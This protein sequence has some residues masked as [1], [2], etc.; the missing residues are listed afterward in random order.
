MLSVTIDPSGIYAFINSVERDDLF[1]EIFEVGTG[2]AVHRRRL[3]RGLD[4]TCLS[5]D[6]KVT[7]TWGH[8]VLL[9]RTPKVLSQNI[10]KVLHQP[11]LYKSLHVDDSAD[12][13]RT[14]KAE[15]G[16]GHFSE[17]I[18]IQRTTKPRH[19]M[20]QE[21]I[22]EGYACAIPAQSHSSEVVDVIVD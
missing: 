13:R 4:S 22:Y 10:A 2:R 5:G 11:S 9:W 12:H 17:S 15:P 7:V 6:G 14:V 8:A 18:H 3:P 19:S 20:Q 1:Q 21:T 16:L